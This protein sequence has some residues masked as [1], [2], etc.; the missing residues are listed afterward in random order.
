MGQLF[1]FREAEK[2]KKLET[3][4]LLTSVDPLSTS[5]EMTNG[6]YH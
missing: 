2:K 1:D 5:L 4:R 6:S 3:P